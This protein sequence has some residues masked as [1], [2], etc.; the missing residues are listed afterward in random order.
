MHKTSFSDFQSKKTPHRVVQKLTFAPSAHPQCC[1]VHE[2]DTRM[3]I[4]G[5][6]CIV[7]LHHPACTCSQ[8]CGIANFWNLSTQSS[9]VCRRGALA[10][11]SPYL[12]F[13][14]RTIAVSKVCKARSGCTGVHMYSHE[15]D[16]CARNCV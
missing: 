8:K 3:S 15:Q 10:V 2:R 16:D 12:L 5:V 7:S 1:T 11:G 4:L 13:C 6:K 9:S 14:V